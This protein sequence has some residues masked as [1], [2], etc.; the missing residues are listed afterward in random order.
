MALRYPAESVDEVRLHHV[1]EH[2]TRSASCALLAS[3]NSWLKP[4]GILHIEVPDFERT[5]RAVVSRLSNEKA[6]YVGLRHIFGSQ[7]AHWAVHYEGHSKTS[8]RRLIGSFGFEPVG[9]KQERYKD[10]Y[11]LTVIAK[12][13]RSLTIAQAEQVALDHLRRFI[14]D[15]GPSENVL[16]RHWMDDF[17]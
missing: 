6:R 9:T 13:S 1:F 11:N 2:F 16:L 7:E 5:A 15:D 14:V 4:D 10:T 3:W 8:L 17:K 12:R